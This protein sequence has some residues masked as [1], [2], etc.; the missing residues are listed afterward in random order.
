VS[1]RSLR[2]ALRRTLDGINAIVELEVEGRPPRKR[3]GWSCRWCPLADECEEGRSW[4]AGT[5][6]DDDA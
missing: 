4:S 1:E 2:S 3:P 6:A 5:G